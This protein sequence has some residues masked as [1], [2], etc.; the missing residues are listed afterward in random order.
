MQ[1]ADAVIIGGGIAGAS[2]A[3]RL[4][5]EMRV[6][7]LEA[8]P[9][10]GYHATGRSAA[11]FVPNYGSGPIRDLTAESRAFFQSPDPEFFPNPLLTPRG[12]LRVAL[13]EGADEH[14]AVIAGAHGAEEIPVSDAEALFPVLNP[15][16][17]VAASFEADVHDID[18]EA[19]LQGFLRQARAAGAH[20]AFGT[21]AEAIERRGKNWTIKA[22]TET[23]T[24]PILINAAGG[25]ADEVAKQASVPPLDLRPYRRSVAL[26]PTPPALSSLPHAPFAVTFP[27]RWYAKL[28]PTGLLVSPGDE[29]ETQPH[30]AY[31]D[32]MTLAEGL[33]RF[34][35]DSRVAVNRVAQSWAG[36]RTFTPDGLPVI[37]PDP[38]A[39][40]FF[41]C[42][43]Q[44]GFGVQT[45]P[46]L[47]EQSA[48]L[49]LGGGASD[50]QFAAARFR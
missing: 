11:V 9:V 45:A 18:V 32:D 43:G 8:E 38:A 34:E 44:G 37:G 46:A 23:Y 5:P 26:L 12:L 22:D 7:L 49:I 10:A 50:L 15:K 4:A 2:L 24:S 16:R 47:A 25:W 28:E 35:M 29:T 39:D 42:A 17:I 20:I 21:S 33:H 48:R 1:T 36:L 31:V 40:G 19:T 14:A 6:V 30:D 41:W 13:A 27:L 3:A